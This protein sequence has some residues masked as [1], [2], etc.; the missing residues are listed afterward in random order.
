MKKINVK[1][2]KVGGLYY[3]VSKK[4]GKKD[5]CW[6]VKFKGGEFNNEINVDW[7]FLERGDFSFME[8]GIGNSDILTIDFNFCRL[9]KKEIMD[10]K[11]SLILYNL[12]K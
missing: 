11:K 12:E 10:F 1:D 8:N 9:N 5:G 4:G 6:V 7:W 2:M 3:I